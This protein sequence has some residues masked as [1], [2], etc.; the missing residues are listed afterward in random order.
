MPLTRGS[1]KQKDINLIFMIK[2]K[3]IV[4]ERIFLPIVL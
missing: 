3:D 4:F 2:G 1:G